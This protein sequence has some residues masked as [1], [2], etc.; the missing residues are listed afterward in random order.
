M[1]NKIKAARKDYVFDMDQTGHKNNRNECTQ[2]AHA[3]AHTR[4]KTT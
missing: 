2:L 1:N 3:R 4:S